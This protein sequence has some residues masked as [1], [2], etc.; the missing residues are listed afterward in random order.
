MGIF[1]GTWRRQR[2]RVS[3]GCWRRAI[4]GSLTGWLTPAAVRSSRSL[5]TCRICRRRAGRRP[6]I[7]EWLQE[8]PGLTWQERWNA[9]GADTDVFV[10]TAEFLP[11]HHAQRRA[12]LQIISAAEA[13][14][15]ARV[16][17]MNRQVAD[18]LDKIITTLEAEG[19]DGKE[20]AAGA[21]AHYARLSDKTVREHWERARKVN[22][23]VLAGRL[24]AGTSRVPPWL[25]R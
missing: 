1:R 10:T 25:P 15:H 22:V 8:Q 9:S 20:A 3:A 7:L 6:R 18:N 23:T 17:E 14:G 13:S 19:E 2:S 16:A 4:R 5:L 24:P 21:S 12:T 11:R